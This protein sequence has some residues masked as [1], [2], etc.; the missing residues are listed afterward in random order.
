MLVLIDFHDSEFTLGDKE[1]NGNF[2]LI[3]SQSNTNVSVIGIHYELSFL[4]HL[5]EQVAGLHK[6][7]LLIIFGYL[8]ILLIIRNK[9]ACLKISVVSDIFAE[10]FHVRVVGSS[11][12]DA[13]SVLHGDI[14]ERD[15]LINEWYFLQLPFFV[16]VEHDFGLDFGEEV[17][18]TLKTH[19][20]IFILLGWLLE[21]VNVV[22]FMLFH[23][24]LS[25]LIVVL[26]VI[27]LRILLVNVHVASLRHVSYI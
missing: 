23:F 4:I 27:K 5:K 11:T 17:S 21:M 16:D 1:H 15:I 19:I 13:G 7:L 22:V 6:E 24:L 25:T 12:F 18:I 3:S 26:M 2:G 9:F 8:N 20:H 14:G 10:T